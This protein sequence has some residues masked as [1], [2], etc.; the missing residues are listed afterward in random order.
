MQVSR[1]RLLT[2]AAIAPVAAAAAMLPTALVPTMTESAVAAVVQSPPKYPWKWWVG[3]SDEIYNEAFDTKEDA[4]AEAEE[5]E[6]GFIAECR[7]QDFNLRIDGGSI[8]EDLYNQ[9]EECVNEDGDFIVCTDEQSKDLGDM[10]S[11]TMLA[12]VEKHNINVTAWMFGGVRNE[13]Q[14]EN[15]RLLE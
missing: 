9:N 13:I 12:W 1:R 3:Y 6:Y 4:M 15:G 5:S 10:L 8:L 7:Q 14:L 2:G 11:A